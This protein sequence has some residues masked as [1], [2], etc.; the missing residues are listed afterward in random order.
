MHPSH[1][2]PKGTPAPFDHR[3][4]SGDGDHDHDDV[5]YPATVP[6]LLVHLAALGAIWTGVTLQAVAV[7][8]ALYF[9]RMWAITAGFHRYFSHR[10]YKTSRVFQFL[11]AFLGQTSAQRGVIWWAAVHRHHHRHSDTPED[12][13]SA[14]HGGFWHSHVGWIFK[15]KRSRAD[16]ESVPDLTRYPEL[17]FLERH[18]YFP[19]FLLAIG[20]YLWLG[21]VGLFVGFFCSTVVL[22]H[23]TFAINSLAHM[24][25][26]Q[27]YLTGDQSRNSLL[28]A[29]ITLGE[30]WHN[31]HH[32]YQSSTRQG[33]RWWEIDITYYVLWGMSKLG[34]VWDL[35]EPPPE[36]VAGKQRLGRKVL[37]KAARDLAD[38]LPS[39][40]ITPGLREAWIL[41]PTFVELASDFHGAR[42]AAR[43]QLAEILSVRTLPDLPSIDQLRQTIDEL[44]HRADERLRQG[45][46]DMVQRI[47]ALRRRAEDTRALLVQRVGELQWP[48]LPTLDDLR[49]QA[50][51]RFRQ[52]PSL[53]EIAERARELVIER[54]VSR[55]LD[56]PELAGAWA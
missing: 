5:V 39:P 33:F 6:F 3:Y 11:L 31:N 9:I 25:G 18:P 10:S 4:L 45:A 32:A 16:Y 43:E 40:G 52:T 13:H 56:D 24:T 1:T 49:E 47:D 29:L 36:L 2:A 54:L 21:W 53:D 15:P 50:A 27:R 51:A 44:R 55:I 38:S 28:L 23:G 46:D 34:L 20:V 19:A 22:Y 48:E 17:R 37:E 30:G 14:L 12:A 41:T 42:V 8:V 26:N 35:R 7:G